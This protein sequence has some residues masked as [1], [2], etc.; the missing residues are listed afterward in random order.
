MCAMRSMI[1][2]ADVDCLGLVV[3]GQEQGELVAAEAEGLAVL[4]ER[5]REP[6]EDAVAGRMA[7]EVV[8]ALEVVDVDEAEAEA[9]PSRSASISS[10][11][12]RSWK[13]R[14]LPSPV[15]GSVSASLIARSAR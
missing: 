12:S 9:A 2:C 14:W 5:G 13:W 8:D 10:R 11:S 15:S 3:L 7:E 4:A 1:A 6:R